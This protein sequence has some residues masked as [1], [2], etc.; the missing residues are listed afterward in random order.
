MGNGSSAPARGSSRRGNTRGNNRNKR[1][2]SAPANIKPKKHAE[3]I[4]GVKEEI[5]MVG[6]GGASAKERRDSAKGG[7]MSKSSFKG[8]TTEA[9][10][11]N[12]RISALL[13]S[14]EGSSGVGGNLDLAKYCAMIGSLVSIDQLVV[15]GLPAIARYVGADCKSNLY[16][17]N[18]GKAE[19]IKSNG[20][21]VSF[22]KVSG[23]VGRAFQNAEEALVNRA[24]K[25]K[26]FDPSFDFP[27]ESWDKG[28]LMV[29]PLVNSKNIVIGAVSIISSET[30][31]SDEYLSEG[32]VLSKQVE[33]TFILARRIEALDKDIEKKNLLLDLSQ[34]V[35]EVL[36]TDELI[37]MI[38]RKAEI[39]MNV[40]RCSLFLIDEI[41]QELYAKVFDG[42]E[43]NVKHKKSP[44]SH[45]HKKHKTKVASTP[46]GLK[47]SPSID[48]LKLQFP[49]GDE[50][51]AGREEIRFPI[52][53]GIAGTVAKEGEMLNIADAYKDP[54]FNTDVDKK[55]GFKTNSILC[56][57]VRHITSGQIIGVAQLVNRKDQKP[58]DEDDEHLFQAFLIFCANALFNAK[59][60]EKAVSVNKQ[61]N[62]LLQVAQS[63][64]EEF[65]VTIMLKKIMAHS[66]QLLDCDRC[67]VF[68]VDE[69]AEELYSRVFDVDGSQV[70]D[71]MDDEEG[72]VIRFPR[73]QGIAGFVATSGEKQN[74]VDC[75]EDSRFNPAIDK[76]T[77]Y[78]TKSMLC[79][80]I[81]VDEERIIGVVQLINKIGGDHF[82]ADDEELFSTF[83]VFCGIALNHAQLYGESVKAQR[84]A[85]VALEMM[86]YHTS[87]N[88]NEL[89]ALKEASLKPLEDI[90]AD[91]W[92]FSTRDAN[93]D[94]LLHACIG[95]FKYFN[96]IE[97]YKIPYD[98]LCNF[99]LSVRK[100]YRDV[101]YHN[102][103][104][105]FSVTNAFFVIAKT[106]NL[107]DYLLE[108]EIFSVLVSALCHD[109]DHRGKSNSFLSNTGSELSGLYESSST[110]EEHHFSHTLTLLNN[111]QND[112]FQ[113][114]PQSLMDKVTET[115]RHTII[116]TDLANHFKNIKVFAEFA[117]NPSSY[118][119]NNV[120]HRKCLIASVMTAADI[121]VIC[122]PWP[123]QHKTAYIIYSEFF[124]QG[125]EEKAQ[126]Q[127][128]IPMMD[129]D[130]AEVPKLQLG[131]IDF[132]CK[133]LYYDLAKF[134]SKFSFLKDG[135]DANRIEWNKLFEEDEKKKTGD[136]EKDD[137]VFLPRL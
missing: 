105:A 124:A 61:R 31:F 15:R 55:T 70:L 104:H 69:K 117:E 129:R 87:C 2:A 20:L 127:T 137:R 93:P 17:L 34:A 8:I 72:K 43:T 99:I 82:T 65:S 74:I 7:K 91:K 68:L 22:E 94:D 14:M 63:I 58:F 25:D 73:N 19:L 44:H 46:G 56:S 115:M 101:P 23:I 111:Q 134:D 12:P 81:K 36:D 32:K 78:H 110:M 96:F 109:I 18:S 113:N 112:I 75:Y 16:I 114:L 95:F 90:G 92:D 100:N 136:E 13:S 47:R 45:S 57:P 10:S 51:E 97:K 11:E 30:E 28:N 67:S 77:G 107:Q 1:R 5:P 39:L 128:P 108:N 132:V 86:S 6:R 88:P 41:K 59:L 135:M 38:L 35:Y 62:V 50:K 131:F 106:V 85:R 133:E 21:R 26:S 121:H 118:D 49:K 53:V 102:W 52:G 42:E 71:E 122:K 98:A 9:E 4:E 27:G 79:M 80:P 40:D 66:P 76:Q 24:H 125:D 103:F 37:L 126:G 60:Y 54:R 120:E 29:F 33:S 3:N 130:K 48:E 64:V 116:S 119:K 84:R 89:S 83:A 123:I